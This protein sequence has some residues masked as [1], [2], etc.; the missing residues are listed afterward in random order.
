MISVISVVEKTLIDKLT[1]ENTENT[2]SLFFI[3]ELNK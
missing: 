2:E 3:N 1:T